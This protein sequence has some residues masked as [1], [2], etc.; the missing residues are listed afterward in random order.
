M[1]KLSPT[2]AEIEELR[3]TAPKGPVVMINLLKFRSDGG[4]AAYRRYLEVAWKAVAEL[5]NG[6]APPL[7]SLYSGRAGKDVADGEDWDFVIVMEYADFDQARRSSLHPHC[8]CR[9]SWAH[10]KTATT[11]QLQETNSKRTDN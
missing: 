6:G 5:E 9:N 8:E 3:S 4:H 7:K 11:T 10:L 2:V 1:T